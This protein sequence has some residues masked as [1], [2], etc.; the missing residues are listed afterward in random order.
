MR[1]C[2][3]LAIFIVFGKMAVSAADTSALPSINVYDQSRAA[4]LDS[5]NVPS[6]YG[7]QSTTVYRSGLLDGVATFFQYTG[8]GF[9]G[10]GVLCAVVGYWFYISAEETYT[11]QYM[12]TFDRAKIKSYY[13][14]YSD[15]MDVVFWCYAV[16]AASAALGSLMFFPATAALSFTPMYNDGRVDGLAVNYAQRF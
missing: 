6:P 13:K 15:T 7:P 3:L 14:T 4:L 10:A 8:A 16:G 9:I 11:N 2:I 1:H 5:L 12:M